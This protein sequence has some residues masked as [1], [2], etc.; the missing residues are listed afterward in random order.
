MSDPGWFPYPERSGIDPVLGTFGYR[1]CSL[2]TNGI[3]PVRNLGPW[4]DPVGER[5]KIDPG[6]V[7]YFSDVAREQRVAIR[8]VPDADRTHHKIAIGG[9]E[10]RRR[11]SDDEDED[12]R[13]K[14]VKQLEKYLDQKQAS[15]DTAVIDWWFEN[16]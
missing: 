9:A 11:E 8:G 12:P 7:R 10:Q 4:V 14:S 6:T 1:S 16:N 5:K 15:P 3:N 2:T 13:K